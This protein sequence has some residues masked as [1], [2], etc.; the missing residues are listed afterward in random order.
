MAIH[1][2]PAE[3]V[4]RGDWAQRRTGKYIR[5]RSPT[6]LR[7]GVAEP[8]RSL[9][10]P[11]TT[12]GPIDHK[13]LSTSAELAADRKICHMGSPESRQFFVCAMPVLRGICMLGVI[14]IHVAIPEPGTNAWLARALIFA[15]CC[16]RY[17][18]PVFIMLSGFYLSLNTRNESAIPLYRRTLKFLI[19]PYVIYSVGYSVLKF[20]TDLSPW[21]LIQSLL[22]ASASAHLGFGLLIIQLY[23]LHPFVR[24]WYRR[25]RRRE[26]LVA[27]VF[28]LQMAWSISLSVWFREPDLLR[29][30]VKVAA[31]LSG[32][33]FVSHVGY[34]IFGYYLLERSA[35]AAQML[36]NARFV[37]AA[38]AVWVLSAAVVFAYWGIERSQ[39]ISGVANV[40]ASVALNLFVP[41][42]S[43]GALAAI[44]PLV[45]K[46]NAAASAAQRFLHSLG[47]YS[48]GIYYFHGFAGWTISLALR[49]ALHYR[50]SDAMFYLLTFLLTPFVTL[51]CIRFLAKLPIGKYLT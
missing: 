44:L 6:R 12:G 23:L 38:G 2:G 48:Y 45:Q 47:L 22:T 39:S 11:R 10:I 21:L 35:E 46:L 17:A 33:L 37:L 27:A 19:V 42:M 41:L 9:E 26:M 29:T 36:R 15:N 1:N 7:P 3:D 13:P 28:L 8:E 32:L 31:R 20:R 34:F 51:V 25:F 5:E 30:D 49:H 50:R 4:R 14:L 24:R 16:A 40:C 43:L 18:V